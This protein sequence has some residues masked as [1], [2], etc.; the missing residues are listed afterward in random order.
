VGGNLV[1]A[2]E[3]VCRFEP[4]LGNHPGLELS[5]PTTAVVEVIIWGLPARWRVVRSGSVCPST[6]C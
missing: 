6:C 1:W 5:H 3:A 4:A 2:R